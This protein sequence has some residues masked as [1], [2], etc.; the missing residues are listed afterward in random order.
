MNE[1]INKTVSYIELLTGEKV[2]ILPLDIKLRERVPMYLL[3]AYDLFEG[4]LY[5][6]YLCFALV[7]KDTDTTPAQYSKRAQALLQATGLS[8]VFVIA[9]IASYNAQRLTKNHVN[10]IVPGK[11]LFLP[12]LFIDLGKNLEDS[13]KPESIPATAQLMIL[14]HLE[15]AVLNGKTGKE[16]AE[17]I[18]ASTANVTRAL[19]WLVAKGFAVVNGGR[20]KH[21]QFSHKGKA[22]WNATLGFLKSPVLRIVRTDMNLQGLM[23][24]QNALAEYGMLIEADHEMV[25]IGP[26]EY[27]AIKQ[28]TN[29]LYGENEIQV[30]MYEPQILATNMMVDK[31][32]LYLS[33]R[34]S[35]DERIQKEL[36]TMIEEIIW[37]E[38]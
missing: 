25:A 31:L 35:D 1:I 10:F 22:L 20:P 13:P 23:C 28:D 17:M 29:P 18:G 4:V 16:I 12:A 34:D 6:K 11:Q 5:D 19:R 26:K 24:G 30:W 38:D 3:G 36:K 7:D 32:S 21:L 37:L 15:A 33:M 14:Y 8:P 27:R 9:N 2:N